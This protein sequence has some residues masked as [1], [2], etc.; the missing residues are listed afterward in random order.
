MERP[1]ALP[2]AAGIDGGARALK[3]TL[4]AIAPHFG[5][6]GRLV[7]A[8]ALHGGHI[9]HTFVATY[10][11]GKQSARYVHQRINQHVFPHPE[12]LMENIARVIAHLRE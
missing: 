5:L 7:S 10:V 4:S 11:R 1:K 6:H 8:I 12:R 3:R 2:P 9:H